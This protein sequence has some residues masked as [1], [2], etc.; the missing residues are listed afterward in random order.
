VGILASLLEQ[1]T[2]PGQNIDWAG[3]LGLKETPAGVHVNQQNSLQQAAVFACV[4]VLSE[5]AAMLPLILYKRLPRGKDRAVD[6]SLYPILRYLPNPEMTSMELRETGMGHLGLWG[7]TF[8]EKDIT[9][10]GWIKA[11]WPLRPDKMK[12]IRRG[13][14]LIYVYQMPAGAEFPYAELPFERI[15]HIRGLGFDGVVGYDPIGLMRNSIGLAMAAEEFGARLFGNGTQL[16][17]TYEHPGKLSEEAYGRLQKSIEKRHTGLTNAHRLMIL[18]EGMKASQVGIPPENAQFLETRKFQVV[19]IARFY[20]MQLHKIGS[21][22]NAT[23][24]NIEHQS[25]EF[26]TDTMQPWLT[27]WEQ[28]IYRDL[29]TPAERTEYFAEHLLDAL[30]R[31]DTTS[32]YTAYNIGRNGGWLSA[33]DIR[34]KENMNPVDGGDVYLVPL[35]MVPA[36]QVGGDSP[37]GG[38]DTGTRGDGD[39]ETRALDRETRAKNIGKGRQRLAKAYERVIRDAVQRVVKREIADVRRAVDKYLSKRDAFQFSTWLK[40]FYEEHRD[41]WKRQILPVLLSYADQVG[42]DVGTELGEDAHSSDDIRQFIDQYVAALAA[43]E[44]GSSQGQL[45]ALLNVALL[46]G[47]NPGEMLTARLDEWEEKRVDKVTGREKNMALNAFVVA[48]YVLSGVVK[49]RW[50]TL[51]DSCPYC[52]NLDGTVVGVEEF[53]LG[54]DTD[55]Q[56]DGADRPLNV[57]FNMGHGPAH[58]GCDCTVVAER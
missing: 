5:T 11:L 46:E 1:R 23:F 33:N 43:R 20:R 57:R 14:R 37:A 41:F 27:R 25:I 54:K 32:R 34:E 4:R 45:Q 2:H 13:G 36:D 40:Q 30:L 31:G 8:F 48:F 42:A 49:K 56:P 53:F 17:V 3:W 29:L 18:E 24:S 52:R 19:D 15:M 35:N 10:G 51:G 7:N 38:D 26:V 12:V 6:H 39:R 55:Y 9:N 50:L 44:V 58:G 22:E 16:G 28:A 21:L 47:E